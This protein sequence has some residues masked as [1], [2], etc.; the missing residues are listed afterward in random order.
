MHVRLP[1]PAHRSLTRS[2]APVAPASAAGRP[3]AAG[4]AAAA[5]SASPDGTGRPRRRGHLMSN[6]ALWPST[7]VT[8]IWTGPTWA[9]SP[10]GILAGRDPWT[11]S[12]TPASPMSMTRTS[13]PLTS[14]IW[15]APDTVTWHSSFLHEYELQPVSTSA[16]PSARAARP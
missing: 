3:E 10:T 14:R 2:S 12:V 16:P 5:A 13:R 1:P 9:V 8:V 7:E 15:S 11:D 4:G 6:L